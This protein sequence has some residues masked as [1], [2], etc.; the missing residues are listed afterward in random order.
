MFE[1]KEK[2]GPFLWQFPPMVKFEP[3]RFEH[4]LS[5]LP[6]DTDSALERA[7]QYQPRMEGKV[8]LEAGP[9]R[10]MRHA[11]EIRHESFMDPAF[12]AESGNDVTVAFH[13]Y[14][15]PLLGAG[16]PDPC[17]LRA[18]AVAKCR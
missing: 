5:L 11:V 7:L 18:P 12:I 10:P 8:S 4:F 13:S 3:E 16:L 14:L 15:L 9:R 2:L 1:L 6:Q 17:H